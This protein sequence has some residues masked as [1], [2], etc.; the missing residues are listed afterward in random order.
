MQVRYETAD[1]GDEP[2][3]MDAAEAG[4]PPS[5]DYHIYGTVFLEHP[6]QPELAIYDDLLFLVPSLCATAPEALES[7]GDAEVSLVDWP[8]VY[9]LRTTG[10]EV[11]V[12]GQQGE[13]ARYPRAELIASLRDCGTRFSEFLGSVAATH[14]RFGAKARS[15]RNLLGA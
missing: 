3:S 7:S 12:T 13:D 1:F 11:H 4:R 10:D 9:R 8:N 2:A 14:P 15:L 6:G 5:E